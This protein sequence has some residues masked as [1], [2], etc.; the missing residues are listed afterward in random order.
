[1]TKYSVPSGTT[2]CTGVYDG[3]MGK[4]FI[5]CYCFTATELFLGKA[6]GAEF[7]DWLLR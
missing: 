5:F 1:M 4:N 3:P 2:P 7:L 6:G